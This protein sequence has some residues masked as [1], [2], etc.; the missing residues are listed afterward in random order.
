MKNE[1]LESIVKKNIKF[2]REKM[3]LSQADLAKKTG[4][5]QNKI[6]RMEN[7][8]LETPIFL[9][10]VEDI[11]RALNIKATD[12]FQKPDFKEKIELEMS[13]INEVAVAV[14]RF[15]EDFNINCSIEKK[16]STTFYVYK[17]I[18]SIKKDMGEGYKAALSK[19]FLKILVNQALS[20]KTIKL[21]DL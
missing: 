19:N 18:F 13:L 15:L 6:A 12:L 16:T 21:E 3:K 2:Y 14:E 8:N 20:E 10:R 5:S 11:A 7:L 4:F 1:G 17:N 9:D